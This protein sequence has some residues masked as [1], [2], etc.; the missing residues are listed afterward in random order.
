MYEICLQYSIASVLKLSNFLKVLS[1]NL[2]SFIMT[3]A[4]HSPTTVA[5]SSSLGSGTVLTG[6]C[7][8]FPIRKLSVDVQSVNTNFKYTTAPKA[9]SDASFNL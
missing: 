4:I 8:D 7:H 2:I 3:C 9:N 6:V 5:F 1:G